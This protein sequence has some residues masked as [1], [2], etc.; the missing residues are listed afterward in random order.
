MSLLTGGFLTGL[1]SSPVLIDHSARNTVASDWGAKGNH[2][3][4]VVAGGCW[5]L[6]RAVV[7][8]ATLVLVEDSADVSFVVDQHFAGALFSERSDEPFGVAVS[9]CLRWGLDHLDAVGG[10]DS[11][12]GG[13]EFANLGRGS[14]S[15]MRGCVRRGPS[16][17][18]RVAWVVQ[19][20]V[21]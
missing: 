2:G 17:R 21:G 10:E 14:G 4:G 12:E 9:P 18:L 11:V 16:N 13:G 20:A 15:G 7:I 6:V 1:G 5:S 3:G 19:T 8:E